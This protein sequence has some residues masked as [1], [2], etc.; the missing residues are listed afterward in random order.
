MTNTEAA[1]ARPRRTPTHVRVERTERLTR[2]L[3]RVHFSG[4]GL[5]A[6]EPKP[7]T[8]AYVKLLF[9][10]RGADYAAPFDPEQI[11]AERPREE[12][13]VTRTYTIRAIDHAAG[14][15][16]ID[17]VVHGDTGLAG[18]WAAAARAGDVIG[19]LGPGGAWAPESEAAHHLF[20]GDESAYPAIAAALD[21][22]PQDAACTV[23]LEVAD[24]SVHPP[25]RALPH[26]NLV[27]VHRDETR[28]HGGG[29]VDVVAAADVPGLRDGDAPDGLRVFVHGNAEMIKEMRR[30]LI[31]EKSVARA[32]ASISGY[33]RPGHDEDAWQSSKR[34]FVQQMEQ[35]Q[36]RA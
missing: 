11:R 18:P 9:P 26:M 2:D 28:S 24:A 29:L 27:W 21:A 30:L 1:P 6:L 17:F 32:H 20:V 31:V 36:D 16:A 15:M 19:F 23:V 33:W 22:L 7:V 35:E 12:W 25:V 4:D 5:R 13:P 8:D 34:E 14:T 3:V 10:P